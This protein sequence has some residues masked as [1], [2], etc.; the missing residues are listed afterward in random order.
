MR[1]LFLLATLAVLTVACT[2][3]DQD[4]NDLKIKQN[5]KKSQITNLSK[6]EV[7]N[8]GQDPKDITPPRR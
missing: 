7:E 4:E 5:A 8:D 2:E 6:A 3:R 1:K